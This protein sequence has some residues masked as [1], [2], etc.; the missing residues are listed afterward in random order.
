[1]ICQF[2]NFLL[3]GKDE[4]R[5]N[6]INTKLNIK[7]VITLDADTNLSLGTA[8]E[9]IGTMAHILNTPVID[10]GKNIVIDG[11]ALIQP[12]VG[13]D[14]ESSRKSL[15]AKIYAGA[16]GTDSY[17]NAISDVYQD[18]F[19]E[20]IFTGKGIYDL[21]LFHKILCDEIPENT[22]LSH[23][24]LEGSYLRCGL[25]TDILVLDGFPY[26]YSSYI[27]RNHRWIRGDWQIAKWITNVITIRDKTKKIN[28]LNALS[29]FKILDNLRRS[30]I[31]VT[32]ALTLVIS[33]ILKILN[34]PSAMLAT[35]A[36]IAL[37]MPTILDILNYIIFRKSV[38]SE[39]ISAHKNILKTISG[40]K[41]SIIRGLLEIAVLPSKAYSNSNAIIKTIY[42]VNISKQNLLEWMTS[43]EA[44][45]QSKN[46]LSAYYKSMWTN[47]LFGVLLI[48]AGI[49]KT[50][51]IFLI[52]GAIFI[53][54]PSVICYIS[55]EEKEE[56][57]IQKINKRDVKY[58]LD[59]AKKTWKFFEDN[60]NQEN[61]FLPPDNYQYD[62]KEKIAH[63]TSPTNIGLG[64]LAV[65]SS[66]D[67]G[68]ITLESAIEQIQNMLITI[69][70]LQKW[71]GHL[72]NWYNTKTLEPLMPKYVST[73]DSGNFVRIFV[74]I[75]TIFNRK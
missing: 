18:N 11:H 29:R 38:N 60:I 25:A 34:L 72:Y 39:F 61:N 66:Y 45:R 2:N 27:A 70:K 54:A 33:G 32:V 43:E 53:I 56:Q 36:V 50:N 75:K 48:I 15:F 30:L 68:F 67:L 19:G 13:V 51:I 74:H 49:I 3:T 52:F 40:I 4:F 44:E 55:Q 59:V 63:R 73:V 69:E 8:K 41:A 21:E 12:R 57:A 16:G 47:I 23:D 31:T 22:V 65:C 35:L 46:T 58:C 17:T 7:Y 9:L 14:L 28:P 20:G 6:T 26:K 10:K 42:R 5:A 62:R 1:M 71:N 37:E 64:L 24:L